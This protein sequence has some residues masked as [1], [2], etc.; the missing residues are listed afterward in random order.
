MPETAADALASLCRVGELQRNHELPQKA[1][2]IEIDYKRA[3]RVIDGVRAKER[4]SLTFAEGAEVLSAYGIAVCPFAYIEYMEE[5]LAFAHESRFPLV[6][7]VDAPALFHRFEKGAVITEIANQEQLGHAIERLS[8]LIARENLRDGKIL[9]QPSLSGRELIFGLNRDPSFGAVLMFG[10]G[11]TLV[12]ALKDVS[13]GVAPL[14]SSDAERMIRSIHAFPL[15]E[16]FR[17]QPPIDLL[18]LISTLH[19]LG[20]L[21]LDFPMISEIDLNPFIAGERTAA[22]DILI[23]L[24]N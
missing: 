12:E 8:D 2:D 19:R 23:R 21:G 9:L 14:S 11:G 3:R 22:V 10:I 20:R 15:L 4:L 13:F 5:A 7:K 16:A 24:E 17:G 6:A 1:P 18:P